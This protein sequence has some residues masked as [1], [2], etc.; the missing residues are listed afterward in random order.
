M[1]Q[2]IITT[3]ASG[4]SG[5]TGI[6]SA[7]ATAIL[8]ALLIGW[9]CW[10]SR[11]I[12][13]IATR[14]WLWIAGKGQAADAQLNEMLQE[15]QDLAQFH[16]HYDLP[17]RSLAHAKRLMTWCRTHDEAPRDVLACG[18]YFDLEQCELKRKK[19]G[20]VWSQAVTSAFATV[21][22]VGA[23]SFATV[24]ALPFSL[25]QMRDSKVWLL[26]SAEMAKP[27]SHPRIS[28]KD[29]TEDK[30]ELAKKSGFNVDEISWLCQSF[31]R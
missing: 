23:A 11:S 27:L 18:S 3:I 13:P 29:C 21:L 22:L 24:A 4:I 15:S 28:A 10:K 2:A 7:L 8:F 17:A 6:P 20:P 12:H 9:F 26:L 14:L 30:A 16:F 31:N 1:D 19:I 25:A 5:L